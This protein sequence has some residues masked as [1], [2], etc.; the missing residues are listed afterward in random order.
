MPAP[1]KQEEIEKLEHLRDALED[2]MEK[3]T[4]V[5]EMLTREK[6]DRDQPWQDEV[7][8]LNARNDASTR[9][10]TEQ[11]RVIQSRRALLEIEE[12]NGG[13]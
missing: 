3:Q 9:I 7:D 1:Q 10:V 4:D 8:E 5:M 2:A 11:N 6:P 12:G 13:P